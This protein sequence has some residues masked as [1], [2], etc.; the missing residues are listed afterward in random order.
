MTKGKILLLGFVMATSW[1]YGQESR[2]PNILWITCEDMS[3]H[4][5]AYGDKQVKTP[6]LDKLAAE[7]I[8]YTN[9]FA[10][11]GVCAPSRSAIITGMYQQSIGTQHMRTQLYPGNSD[12]Y[13]PGYVGYSAVVPPDV[14][15]FTEYLRGAGYYCTNNVKEDYQFE[16]P[17]TAWDESS[18]NAHW[19]NRENPDQ[20]F[21]S[22]FNIT[23][24]H[25]S[26][27]W[28]RSNDPLLVDPASV[29]VP[30]YYPDVPEVRKDIARHLSNVMV[31]DEQA[32]QILTQLK[33][34]GLEDNTIV[35]FYSDHGDGLPFV[36]RELYDRGIRVPLI[37]RFGQNWSALS[38]FQ[39]R[40][41]VVDDQLVSLVDLAPTMLSLTGI[42]IPTHLQGQAFL[43]RAKTA[44]RKYIHAARDRMDSEYDRVRAIHDSR[45]L[46]LRNYMPEKPFYQNIGY[47]LHQPMMRVILEMKDEGKLNKEQMYW[48]RERKPN[49]ELYDCEKDPFQFNNLAN[50]P[51]FK[52]QLEEM[53]RAFDKW[54]N[55]VG[56]LSQMQ[57]SSMVKRWWNGEDKAPVTGKPKVTIVKNRIELTSSTPGA[58]IGY[59]FKWKEN[60]RVYTGAVDANTQDSLY[61]I[62]QRIGYNKSDL[63]SVP[64]QK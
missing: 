48:F 20:P 14:K 7:G 32:G 52:D 39:S 19:R 22:V 55:A 28:L 30:P 12:A 40:Q 59:K 33:E 63:I 31:M 57:E 11:A 26:Q 61:V 25:E 54:L 35:F 37:I 15:C 8:R 38:P 10:T 13:P 1:L 42:K 58:S 43:G 56:D 3:P 18:K 6:N 4:L 46:Y 41:S 9:A 50:D 45:F 29:S 17:P 24:T 21:F 36:K 23:T 53:R 64:L 2:R 44:P 5:G 49:E 34:D 51:Q 47:R 60:W 62:A 27:V 16:A